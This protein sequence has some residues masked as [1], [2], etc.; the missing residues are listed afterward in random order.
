MTV[1]EKNQRIL[2]AEASWPIFTGGKNSASL[3]KSKR[4]ENQKILWR[5]CIK[6]LL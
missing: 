5:L 4:L 6:D 2:K 3:R 1:D